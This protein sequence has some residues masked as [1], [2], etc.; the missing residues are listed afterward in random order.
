MLLFTLPGTPFFY[1]GD[2]IGTPE[3]SIPPDRVQDPFERLV[4][5]FGLNR[6]PER[7]PMRWDGTATAG[8]TSGEPWLPIG[9][10][11]AECNVA[12]QRGDERSLLHL[13]RRLIALRHAEPTLVAGC[14]E[15]QPA[16]GDLLFYRRHHY[17]NV[18]AVAL[19][20]GGSSHTIPLPAE[21]EVILSTYLDRWGERAESVTSIRP[22]Q[23]FSSDAERLSPVYRSPGQSRQ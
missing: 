18:I 15:P 20:F 16:I 23:A 17:G 9:E 8:F 13:Y 2:E 21:G 7:A 14:Y 11:I 1:A 12:T 10:N 22:E 19:N 5:G 3:I 4:P 6:D